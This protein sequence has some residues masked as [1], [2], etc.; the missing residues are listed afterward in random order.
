MNTRINLLKSLLQLDSPVK[1]ILSDLKRYGSDAVE[2]EALVTL[3]REQTIS[4]LQRFLSGNI[5]GK[6]LY[7]WA[8]ALELREDID[9]G[10]DDDRGVIFDVVSNISTTYVL[11]G[12]ITEEEAESYILDLMT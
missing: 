12:P 8:E 9:F 11:R 10:A 3:T 2:G 7:E 4:V 6:E 1:D 5:T